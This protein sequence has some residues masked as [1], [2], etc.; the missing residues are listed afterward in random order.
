MS[1]KEGE[2][3]KEEQ[4][5][6]EAVKD[7]KDVE[8]GAFDTPAEGDAAAP[9]KEGESEAQPEKVRFCILLWSM[10][11]TVQPSSTRPKLLSSRPCQRP[12]YARSATRRRSH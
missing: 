5:E 6:V 2:T 8:M 9:S 7:G 10:L 3:V 4:P 1:A 11:L 12:V